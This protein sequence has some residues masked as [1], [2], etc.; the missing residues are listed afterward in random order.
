MPSNWN[1]PWETGSVSRD[2]VLLVG[3][4]PLPGS[5][6][7]VAASSLLSVEI[8]LDVTTGVATNVL[9]HDLSPAAA[10][11]LEQLFTGKELEGCWETS[12]HALERRYFAPNR[13]ALIQAVQAAQQQ[14]LQ[15]K[16]TTRMGRPGEPAG[17]AAP[18]SFIETPG[19]R[20][21]TSRKGSKHQLA[22]LLVTL[23]AHSKLLD[24]HE[25]SHRAGQPI[26]VEARRQ[27][28]QLYAVVQQ[29]LHSVQT[30]QGLLEPQIEPVAIPPL[31]QRALRRSI[32]LGRQVPVEQ[33]LPSDLAP[34]RGDPLVLEEALVLLF[35]EVASYAMAASAAVEISAER[36]RTELQV[37]IGLHQRDSDDSAR[38]ETEEV[39]ASDLLEQMW[40]GGLGT[41]AA[42]ALVEHQGG[43]LWMQD[44]FPQGHQVLCLALPAH[45]VQEEPD[46]HT[47]D[48]RDDLPITPKKSTR[49]T[50]AWR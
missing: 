8:E 24:G 28:V 16:Q 1:S 47:P 20:G 35:D 41:L 6:R 30:E 44:S 23:L 49:I 43:K 7:R 36:R 17:A 38:G 32:A 40:E 34:A 21:T 45:N 48:W 29:I 11:L 22:T 4:A 33:R 25:E 12:I 19:S 50:A 14:F 18:A 37:T 39:T 15:W 3:Q 10:T 27:A 5:L 2:T 26:P 46:R 9:C 31:V 13:A 42:R